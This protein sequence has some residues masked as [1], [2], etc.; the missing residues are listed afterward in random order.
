[1]KDRTG[2]ILL[3]N[4]IKA[5]LRGRFYYLRGEKGWKWKY[6]LRSTIRRPTLRCVVDWDSPLHKSVHCLGFQNAWEEATHTVGRVA[7]QAR[8]FSFQVG[9]VH[10]PEG[11][12][13][14]KFL[15]SLSK[16]LAAR[17]VATSQSRERSAH[18]VGEGHGPLAR[19]VASRTAATVPE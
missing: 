11:L 7:S 4:T 16:T 12:G 18:V 17:R 10:V 3:A 14:R 6:P 1:M 19:R 9:Q 2:P 8:G 13:A 15:E 5:T